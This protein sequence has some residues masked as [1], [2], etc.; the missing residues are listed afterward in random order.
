MFF[1]FQYAASAEFRFCFHLNWLHCNYTSTWRRQKVHVQ[2]SEF[3][4]CVH[5]ISWN[6]ALTIV[7]DKLKNKNRIQKNKKTKT[8]FEN[9]KLSRRSMYSYGSINKIDDYTSVLNNSLPF[10]FRHALL[11]TSDA[12]TAIV[13]QHIYCLFSF[14][15]WVSDW[16]LNAICFSSQLQ[17]HKMSYCPSHFLSVLCSCCCFAAC[18]CLCAPCACMSHYLFAYLSC[19]FYCF[20]S[21][22]I[23]SNG[24]SK[25][26]IWNW[27]MIR[28]EAFSM[29]ITILYVWYGYGIYELVFKI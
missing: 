28:Y 14:Y 8:K 1:F 16:Q 27:H 7:L 4:W 21:C 17:F 26:K 19:R 5:F 25:C 2:I 24:G 22:N 9:F 11:I 20:Q 13:V 3:L 18:S 23:S 29:A 10:S 15:F 6:F 12:S